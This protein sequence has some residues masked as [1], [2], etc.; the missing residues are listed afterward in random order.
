MSLGLKRG[1]AA[2]AWWRGR[3]VRVKKVRAKHGWWRMRVRG[4]HHVEGEVEEG[5]LVA[6]GCKWARGKAPIRCPW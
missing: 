2:R 5:G 1:A 6:M 4:V 3:M